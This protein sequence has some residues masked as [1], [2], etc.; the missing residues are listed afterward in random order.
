MFC[1]VHSPSIYR[2]TVLTTK[3]AK[4][5]AIWQLILGLVHSVALESIL[6][7]LLFKY[8]LTAELKLQ[9]TCIQW[10][11]SMQNRFMIIWMFSV[12]NIG[13]KCQDT[14]LLKWPHRYKC[15]SQLLWQSKSLYVVVYFIIYWTV[16]ITSPLSYHG[17][18]PIAKAT[19]Q[20]KLRILINGSFL[21][22][23]E[24]AINVTSTSI[25]KYVA[26]H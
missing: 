3:E 19:K 11:S 12:V 13:K 10:M 26:L 4:S 22:C 6:P 16:T 21:L 18:F 7:K 9:K 17:T 2:D 23:P 15:N 25:Y 24:R 14:S 1:Y 20:T 8:T 5:S